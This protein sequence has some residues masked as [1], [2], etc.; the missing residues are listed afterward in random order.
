MDLA[1]SAIP[2]SFTGSSDI[3]AVLSH[4]FTGTTSSVHYWGAELARAGFHVEG[5]CLSG[6]GTHW[7]DMNKCRYEDW[8]VEMHAAVDR[9]KERAERVFVGGLSM[10]GTLALHLAE[11]RDDLAGIIL[12]NH[13]LF[14]QPDWRLNLVPVLRF[15]IASTGSICRDIK[16]PDIV[17]AAYDRTPL[18]GLNELMKM[19]KEVRAGLDR[20]TQPTLIFKSREDHVIPIESA[21]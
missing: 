10:G 13:A 16:D 5:P 8:V 3:G 18:T 9:I 20:V 21:T 6:H 11:H 7:R 17:E 12:V 4:G 19:L 15:F 2:F 14:L 1:A